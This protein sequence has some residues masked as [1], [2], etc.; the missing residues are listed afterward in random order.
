MNDKNILLVFAGLPGSGKDTCLDYLK[1][2]YDSKTY[3]FTDFLKDGLD[4]FFLEFNRDNLIKLSECIRETFGEDTLAKAMAEKVKTENA[5][6]SAIGNARRPADIKYLSKIPG[7][8]LIKIEA[9]IKTRYERIKTRGEKTSDATQTFEQFEADHQRSTE[10]SILEI[11]K[12]A[13]EHINNDGNFDE[14]HK[15]LDKL[16]NTNI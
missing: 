16:I 1:E 13:T 7:F 5:T 10:L 3:S 9:D 2:K 4:S 8:V 6:I 15:Q 14:L 12:Q 11:A